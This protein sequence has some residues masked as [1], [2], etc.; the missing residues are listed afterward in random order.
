MKKEA[1]VVLPAGILERDLEYPDY[2]SKDRFPTD[3][4]Y[5]D[6]QFE[7]WFVPGFGWCIPTLQISNAGRNH[8]TRRTYAVILDTGKV[9]RIGHGPHV[10]KTITVYVRKSRL[11]ALQKFLDLKNKGSVD[12]N[13]IR[14]RISTRRAQTA[15]RRSGLFF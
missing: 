3:L 14:D 7:M 6:K 8:S 12:A 13:T 5:E 10:S 11:E 1:A 15:L 2:K 4:P 9:C